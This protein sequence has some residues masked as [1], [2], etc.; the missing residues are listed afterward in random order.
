MRNSPKQIDTTGATAG[1]TLIFN[2]VLDEMGFGPMI[3]VNG[4]PTGGATGQMLV[5]ASSADYVLAWVTALSDPSTTKGDLLARTASVLARLAVGTDGLVLTA[6]STTTTGLKW[7]VAPGTGSLADPTTTKGDLIV[8]DSTSPTRLPVGANGKVIVA[9][10]TTSLG[11]AW[12]SAFPVGS[13]DAPPA[14]PNAHDDEFDGTS[15]AT[16]FATPTSPAATDVNVTR[17]GHLYIQSVAGSSAWQGRYQTVPSFPFTMVAKCAANLR[18]GNA[19][20]G[21]FLAPAGA[22][23]ATNGTQMGWVRN[24]LSFRRTVQTLNGA[25]VTNNGQVGTA[26][27]GGQP[28]YIKV[29]VTNATTV[30]WW[31]SFDGWSWMPGE[32]AFNPGFTPGIM[33]LYLSEESASGGVFGFFDF[34]RVT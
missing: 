34:F 15:T 25:F 28:F 12:G 1:D 27:G 24:D 18:S 2:A 16:W 31:A 21:V 8:R 20:A 30:S 29:T 26:P 23:G 6:D 19:R 22:T 5:K 4:V 11:V 9:D 3:A 13:A 7:A 32:L 14:S 33:G 17:L 10:S